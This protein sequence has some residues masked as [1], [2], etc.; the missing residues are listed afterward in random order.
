MKVKAKRCRFILVVVLHY[1]L[2][3]KRVHL[4]GQC[5]E[6]YVTETE[7]PEVETKPTV[8]P[9]YR[10]GFDLNSI[11][12]IGAVIL[13]IVAISIS[14]L[15]V[16]TMR[17]HQRA[18]VWPYLEISQAYNQD[19]FRMTLENKGVGPALIKRFEMTLDGKPAPDLD[20]MIIDVV[21]EEN[22]FSYDLYGS[23]NPSNGVISAGESVRLFGVPWEDR[24][25]LFTQRANNRVNII[26]CYCSIHDQC[27]QTS[28]LT[29]E[30][31]EVK[32]CK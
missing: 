15:E 25:R 2:H 5:L 14:V 21:G 23:N 4:L 28:M 29:N 27:W 13:S 11:A 7:A 22:A 31:T 19:G 32:A 3:A 20:K 8:N 12:T 26:A 17:T 9:V 24:T 16:S 18:S 10:R 30:A 1:K 6:R